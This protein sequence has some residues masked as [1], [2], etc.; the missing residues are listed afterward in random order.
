MFLKIGFG[1]SVGL[2]FGLAIALTH[3][4]RAFAQQ[5]NWLNFLVSIHGKPASILVDLALK[6][7]NDLSRYPFLIVTGPSI[8]NCSPTGVPVPSD[9]DKMEEVLDITDNFI[10]GLTPKI[11]AGTLTYQCQRTNHYYVQDTTGIRNAIARMYRRNYA[12]Y[13]YVIKIKYEPTWATYQDFLYPTDTLLNEWENNNIIS[14]ML[15]AGDS[16]S[17]VRTISFAACFLT[18]SSRQNFVANAIDAGYTAGTQR[19]IRKSDYRY[20]A[21]VITKKPIVTKI[22]NE[23][24]LEIKTLVQRHS[25]SYMKWYSPTK[26]PH[27]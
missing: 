5:Q 14:T 7:R 17:G 26:L 15:S 13:D 3:G 20:C 12:N 10:T 23:A 22:L 4:N 11:L 9:I 21:L 25:G 1:C 24:S 8:A 16:L 2:T 18:D 27:H 6:G 19:E